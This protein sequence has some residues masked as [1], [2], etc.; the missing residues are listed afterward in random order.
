[1]SRMAV[2]LGCFPP[3]QPAYC[4]AEI[5]QHALYSKKYST[6]SNLVIQGSFVVVSDKRGQ[7]L[8]RYRHKASLF[9]FSSSL[10]NQDLLG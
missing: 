4:A 1:M 5:N 3:V 2:M 10:P 6:T 7:F 8:A 9:F